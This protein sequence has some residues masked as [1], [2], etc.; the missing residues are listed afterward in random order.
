MQWANDYGADHPVVADPGFNETAQY[1]YASSSFNGSFY[2]PNMQLLSA[3][4][5]VEKSN[6]WIYQSDIQ[7]VLP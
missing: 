4:R 6:D 7:A 5:V 3:G 1:L 2:L